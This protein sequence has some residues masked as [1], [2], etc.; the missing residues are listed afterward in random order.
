MT[1][2]IEFA[3]FKAFV[4]LP[5]PKQFALAARFSLL[6]PHDPKR[7]GR[8]EEQRQYALWVLRAR[9]MGVLDDLLAA[10]REASP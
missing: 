8:R 2:A 6:S 5:Y 4:E 10:A 3:G 9:A 1:P 7:K